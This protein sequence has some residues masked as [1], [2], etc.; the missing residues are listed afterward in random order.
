MNNAQEAEIRS[1]HHYGRNSHIYR[2]GNAGE[3]DT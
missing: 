2:P 1:K 3:S